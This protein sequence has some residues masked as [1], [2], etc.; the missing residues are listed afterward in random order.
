M[1]VVPVPTALLFLR[2]CGHLFHVAMLNPMPLPNVALDERVRGLSND[3]LERLLVDLTC[4]DEV[5]E[6]SPDPFVQVVEELLL[7]RLPADSLQPAALV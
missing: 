3:P 4:H 2:D 1:T 6:L 5:V 7:I